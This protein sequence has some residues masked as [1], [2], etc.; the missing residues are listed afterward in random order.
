MHFVFHALTIL[1]LSGDAP[2]RKHAHFSM[3]LKSFFTNVLKGG[4]KFL[5]GQIYRFGSV[6]MVSPGKA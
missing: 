1:D 2:D 4:V 3:T 6:A 5:L